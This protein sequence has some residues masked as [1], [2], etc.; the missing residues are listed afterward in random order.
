[1]ILAGIFSSAHLSLVVLDGDRILGDLSS[2]GMSS[3]G[4]SSERR[5]AWDCDPASEAILS[6]SLRASWASW[7]KKTYNKMHPILK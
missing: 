1:M 4:V 5:E 7:K 6:A 2:S 3:M